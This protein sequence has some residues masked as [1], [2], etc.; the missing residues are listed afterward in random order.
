MITIKMFSRDFTIC[1]WCYLPVKI[2]YKNWCFICWCKNMILTYILFNLCW[3]SSSYLDW[4]IPAG[5]LDDNN[6]Y[7][8]H[9]IYFYH[10][11]NYV[12]PLMQPEHMEMIELHEGNI[13]KVMVVDEWCLNCGC[14]VFHF[15]VDDVSYKYYC[16]IM[17]KK[18]NF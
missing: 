11:I 9:M 4:E 5:I 14:L 16:N 17:F 3:M 8:N 2:I 18:R 12:H 10:R 6:I 7:I 13:T 15:H 1:W